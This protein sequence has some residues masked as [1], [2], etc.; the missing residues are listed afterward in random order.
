MSVG[1]RCEGVHPHLLAGRGD[2]SIADCGHDQ[3]F[4]FSLVGHYSPF[5]LSRTAVT[6]AFRALIAWATTPFA[7][8]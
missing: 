7:K 8:L 5:L 3:V 2:T 6:A 4:A 1:V